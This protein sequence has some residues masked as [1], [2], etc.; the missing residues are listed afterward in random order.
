M[1]YG[2][3][4][5]H[6]VLIE[7][8]VAR[9]HRRTKRPTSDLTQWPPANAVRRSAAPRRARGRDGSLTCCCSRPMCAEAIAFYTGVLGCAYL[10]GPATTSLSCTASMAA[11][12]I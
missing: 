11:T 8:K 3:A 4:I 1:E 10:T 6:G 9:N 5:T 7:I 12:I 2:F